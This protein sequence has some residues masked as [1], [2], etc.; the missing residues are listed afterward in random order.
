VHAQQ[1]DC[2]AGVNTQLWWYDVIQSG[3]V[4]VIQLRNVNSGKCLEV[5]D[6][7]RDNGAPVQQWDCVGAETQR[8]ESAAT[9]WECTDPAYTLAGYH[10]GKVLEVENSST[11]NGARVQQW[12]SAGAPGQFWYYR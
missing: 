12:D 11:Y 6:S 4:Q 8:W 10:S 9:C 7:R 5:A 3:E 2:V 1:W